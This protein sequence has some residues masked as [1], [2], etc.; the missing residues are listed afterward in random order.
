MN[1]F[2]PEDLI[3]QDDLNEE[4]PEDLVVDPL[5]SV[6]AIG[7]WYHGLLRKGRQFA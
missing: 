2:F 7:L 3:W 1:L 5:P 4:H 6:L